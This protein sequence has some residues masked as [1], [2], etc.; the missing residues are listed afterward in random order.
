MLS[1]VDATRD[2]SDALTWAWTKGKITPKADFGGP[3]TT[4][5]YDLCIYDGTATPIVQAHVEPGGLCGPRP[6]WKPTRRGFTDRRLLGGEF[7]DGVEE[8]GAPIQGAKLGNLANRAGP[9]GI[10][11]GLCKKLSRSCAD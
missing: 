7:P 6:C 5:G 4:T 3:L 11:P 9:H 2:G 8:R 1:L 10:R